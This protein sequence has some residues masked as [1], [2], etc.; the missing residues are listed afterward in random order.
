MIMSED[1]LEIDAVMLQ[2]KLRVYCTF[3]AITKEWP[4]TI[5]FDENIYVF[6]GQMPIPKEYVG[7]YAGHAE[8][9]PT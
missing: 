6:T 1:E 7:I 5:M 2:N 4:E 8:Y 3:S 9:K